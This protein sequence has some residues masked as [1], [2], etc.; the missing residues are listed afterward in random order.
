MVGT[1]SRPSQPQ[2]LAG[3][4][5][6]NATVGAAV[7]KLIFQKF[8]D[9][10]N[11]HYVLQRHDWPLMTQ[12]T[13][14]VSAVRAPLHGNGLTQEEPIEVFRGLAVDD[15]DEGN[16]SNAREA[17]GPLPPCAFRE[18][19]LQAVATAMGADAVEAA[20]HQRLGSMF[21]VH[22][23]EISFH[24]R[25]LL[26][27]PG[28]MASEIKIVGSSFANASV[29]PVEAS[30]S[31][32]QAERD[33]EFSVFIVVL[34]TTFCVFEDFNFEGSL[35]RHSDDLFKPIVTYGMAELSFVAIGFGA[36]HLVLN[37]GKGTDEIIL[38]FRDTTSTLRMVGF[39]REAASE[40]CSFVM[41]P[42]YRRVI[43]C[44]ERNDETPAVVADYFQCFMAQLS[45]VVSQQQPYGGGHGG[46][47]YGGG[48]THTSRAFGT[49]GSSST[50]GGGGGALDGLST[51]SQQSTLYKKV[52][53]SM[54]D[55]D[56][57]VGNTTKK[58][59]ASGAGGGS[60]FGASTRT[61]TNFLATTSLNFSR[62]GDG[63]G[64]GGDVGSPRGGTSSFAS[65]ADAAALTKKRSLFSFGN[66][67]N[68]AKGKSKA[69]AAAA[70]AAY[71]QHALSG[72][73]WE[74]RSYPLRHIPPL[75]NTSWERVS[76]VFS[77]PMY[78][79]YV[80]AEQAHKWAGDAAHFADE[81]LS[82]PVLDVSFVEVCPRLSRVPLIAVL[83]VNMM[84]GGG[85]AA[86]GLVDKFLLVFQHDAALE[87]FVS[88]IQRFH[89]EATAAFGVSKAGGAAG[90]PKVSAASV[91]F[92]RGGAKDGGEGGAGGDGSGETSTLLVTQ[93]AAKAS[94]DSSAIS[95]EQVLR[96][97]LE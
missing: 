3:I 60:E 77:K 27:P 84:G 7:M 28:S 63:G 24:I 93:I 10:R 91:L 70:A 19:L 73:E 31:V 13:G 44:I 41:L 95:T 62:G 97:V 38:H 85:A 9:F 57:T 90:S 94:Q 48:D 83:H 78:R 35:A 47:Y 34:S 45:L 23:E 25:T 30:A 40:R 53:M 4:V 86:A 54:L 18:E 56:S 52:S 51:R 11:P 81:V 72:Y 64:G 8:R 87:A 43:E 21:R 61:H 65:A 74:A 80:V 12:R 59:D 20:V 50:F 68:S 79:V 89:A 29:C 16:N 66:K 88:S 26:I 42:W 46:S 92:G 58:G 55:F 76:V 1:F 67:G 22:P 15:E 2:M 6:P 49:G 17:L 33:K 82:F 75:T 69:E 14:H 32:L 71:D 5:V 36:Q 96:A 37:F 39:L